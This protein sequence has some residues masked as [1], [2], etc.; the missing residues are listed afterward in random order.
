M[1]ITENVPKKLFFVQ[2]PQH[3]LEAIV[4]YFNKRGYDI[5]GETA[6]DKV[7][8][9]V[10]QQEPAFIFVALDHVDDHISEIYKQLIHE[11]KSLIVPYITSVLSHDILK[12]MQV[13]NPIKLNPPLT[14]PSIMRFLDQYKSNLK[15]LKAKQIQMFK[16]IAAPEIQNDGQTILIEPLSEAIHPSQFLAEVE[17]IKRPLITSI[18]DLTQTLPITTW[19]EPFAMPLSVIQRKSLDEFCG[20]NASTFEP[21]IE[22]LNSLEEG[23]ES[24]IYALLVES[25]DCS[26]VFVL[27]S[28]MTL[29]DEDV[30][31][32]IIELARVLADIFGKIDKDSPSPYRSN[33]FKVKSE[34]HES[35]AFLREEANFNTEFG[36][37]PKT[38][39][40]SFYS[41]KYNPFSRSLRKF[42]GFVKLDPSL[43]KA[44]EVIDFEVFIELKQNNKLVKYIKEGT[45]VS[46][47][48]VNR[49]TKAANITAYAKTA[50]EYLWYSHSVSAFLHSILK[51]QLNKTA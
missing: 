25:I 36:T 9:A 31:I 28:N 13:N 1:S 51:R 19:N 23:P 6:L 12:L 48:M 39:A 34:P 47:D 11:T 46:E 44:N 37:A 8:A 38:A 22:K 7:F 20:D 30:Q 26:G 35:L 4:K 32:P 50:D 40:I 21:L 5:Q 27:S 10:Q 2:S 29:L 49:L 18:V 17:E 43:I 41:L 42:P 3:N 45:F 14:G 15:E 33:I 24:S 16:P